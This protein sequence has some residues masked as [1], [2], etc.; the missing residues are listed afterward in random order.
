MG[1][2]IDSGPYGDTIT[3]TFTCCHCNSI[4]EMQRGGTVAMCHSCW[5]RV[6][7]RC[8]AVGTCRPFERKLDE[9]E[10]RIRA[11]ESRGEFLSKIGIE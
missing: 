11:A 8:H 3:E 7:A 4:H 1:W 2:M 9:F 5:K 6:C 10:R